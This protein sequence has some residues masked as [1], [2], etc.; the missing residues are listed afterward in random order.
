[1]NWYE[2]YPARLAAEIALWRS[3]TNARV[4]RNEMTILADEDVTLGSITFGL[5]L[6]YPKDFPFKS[7]RV[8]LLYPDLPVSVGVHRYNDG[9]LC[10]TSPDDWAP[11]RTGVWIRGRAV[12][13]LHSLILCG[14]TG[15]WPDLAGLA[16]RSI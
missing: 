6:T 12:L 8:D 4:L 11:A 10:L 13:W 1:M 2:R 14:E 15:V 9:S 5:R 16:A 7:P 3:A